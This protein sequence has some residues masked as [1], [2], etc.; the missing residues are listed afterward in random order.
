M[1]R[2]VIMGMGDGPT[3]AGTYCGITALMQVDQQH[4]HQRLPGRL[5]R[6]ELRNARHLHIGWHVVRP[7]C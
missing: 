1:S 2:G 5:H 7:A 4:G 3:G 6:Y